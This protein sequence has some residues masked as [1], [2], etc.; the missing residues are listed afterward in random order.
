MGEGL[1]APWGGTTLHMV[2]GLLVISC[3]SCGHSRSSCRKCGNGQ[4]RMFL[5]EQG[6]GQSPAWYM[7][8]RVET[9]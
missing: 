8:P 5:S 2:K 3:D 4:K 7:V 6:A 9:E 1:G